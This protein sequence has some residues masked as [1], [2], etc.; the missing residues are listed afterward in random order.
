MQKLGPRPQALAVQQRQ[1]AL[2][3][4]W[5]ALKLHVEQRR[6]QLEQAQL[7]AHFHTAVRL[8]SP[9]VRVLYC[10]CACTNKALDGKRV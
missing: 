9:G 6:T 4:A 3:Q 1:Q 8:L 5:E 10:E 2:K 7:L